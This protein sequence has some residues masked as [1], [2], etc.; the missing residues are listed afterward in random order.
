M[1]ARPLTSAVAVQAITALVR[2]EAGAAE[3]QPTPGQWYAA[4][5]SCHAKTTVVV[6]DP[7]ALTGKHVIAEC[8]TE[9]N[10]RL[11]ATAHE[12][13]AALRLCNARLLARMHTDS[14]DDCAAYSAACAAIAKATGSA[15]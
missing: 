2:H 8:D 13:L 7:T 12:L 4:A 5:W 10:A 3:A 1:K 6:D 15:T 14:G 9:E 11:T